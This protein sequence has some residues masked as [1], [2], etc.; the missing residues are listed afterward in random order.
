MKT[1]IL[2]VTLGTAALAAI[3][4]NV[5]ADTALRSPRA[6]GSQIKAAPDITAAQP[7][8]VDQANRS[9]RALGNQTATVKGTE[10]AV[11]KCPVAGSPKYLATAGNA[12]RTTCCKHTVAGCPTMSTCGN[13]K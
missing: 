11:T 7:A 1:R 4:L 2:L 9:P 12:A 6:Q 13:V 3:T 10:P 5:N 8:Q